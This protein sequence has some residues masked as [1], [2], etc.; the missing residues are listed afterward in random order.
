MPRKKWEV[1]ESCYH[2]GREPTPEEWD[3]SS[4]TVDAMNAKDA[5]EKGYE[6]DCYSC[7]EFGPSQAVWVREVGTTIAER[8]SVEVEAVP[9]FIARP[10]R[11]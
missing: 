10:N 5:A 8:F 11:A 1:C 9:Q 2:D 7:C 3:D 4:R 6:Q